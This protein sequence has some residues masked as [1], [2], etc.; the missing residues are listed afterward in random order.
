ML[1]LEKAM[2]LVADV[3]RSREE[4]RKAFRKGFGISDEGEYLYFMNSEDAAALPEGAT[5][6]LGIRTETF[7]PRGHIYAVRKF[8]S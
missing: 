4:A 7:C 8:G 1:T 5:K 2:K 6:T 3:E